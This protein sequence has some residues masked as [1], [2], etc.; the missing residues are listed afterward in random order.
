MTTTPLGT[1]LPALGYPQTPISG[2]RPHLRAHLLVARAQQR[3]RA[4]LQLARKESR[5]LAK[6]ISPNDNPSP[7]P[8]CHS[9][10]G[11]PFPDETST[12]RLAPADPGQGLPGSH[13]TAGQGQSTRRWERPC[14][15]HSIAAHAGLSKILHGNRITSLDQH[16]PAGNRTS[17]RKHPTG[18]ANCGQ[19]HKMVIGGNSR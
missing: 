7:R 9:S 17:S 6:P 16:P 11:R 15:R 18:P 4:P 10:D 8:V 5:P 19:R 3:R 12:R 14:N 2:G 13:P 1:P